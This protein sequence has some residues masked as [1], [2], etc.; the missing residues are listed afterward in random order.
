MNETNTKKQSFASDT[1]GRTMKQ[2]AVGLVILF[3][4]LTIAHLGVSMFLI[5]DLGTDTFTIFI[6]GISR[7]VGLSIGTCH[8]IALIILMAVMLVTTKGYVKPGTVVCAFCGG[9]IIDFF[10]WIFGDSVSSASPMWQ[11][12]A[13][14]VLGCVILSLGMS[15]VIESNSGTGP[16]DLIAIILTDKLQPKFHLEFRWVRIACDVFY[17]SGSS[18]RGKAGYRNGGGSVS[19]RTDSAVLPSEEP[20]SNRKNYERIK[21]LNIRE[22][23]PKSRLMFCPER[24]YFL[25]FLLLPQKYSEAR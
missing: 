6:Q 4:G 16:N 13:V 10:L 17:R 5:S 20:E 9:W 8:V 7:T 25:F 23:A 18:S 14:M 3:V 2:W 19:H 24:D 1:S 15:V 11:R 12:V 22:A 21:N